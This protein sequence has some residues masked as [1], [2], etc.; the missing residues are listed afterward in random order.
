[1]MELA[2]TQTFAPAQ[3]L[4]RYYRFQ[5][6]I[7]DLT[8]WAFLFGRKEIMAMLPPS[9]G[10]SEH[11]V[12]VGCG[13]GFNLLALQDHRP[14]AWI[15][16]LDVSADMLEKARNKT[17]NLSKVRLLEAP[18]GPTGKNFQDLD[19]ILISYALTMMNPGWEEILEQAHADLRPGGWIAVVDF[20]DSALPFFKQH[21]S[22]HHVRMDGH[23]L[24]WLEKHFDTHFSEVRKAYQ[25]AWEYFTFVGKK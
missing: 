8:R 14:H 21:M 9:S 16:G 10:P 22:G 15:T 1:M 3:Q 6:R 13:T 12:E 7:Y 19:G 24:P 2:T 5:S 17:M 4:R 20:H 18:Y 23:L 25:G 11:I